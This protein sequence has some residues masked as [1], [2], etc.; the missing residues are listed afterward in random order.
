VLP[1]SKSAV[2]AAVPTGTS[3]PNPDPDIPLFSP[4]EIAE[5]PTDQV[6]ELIDAGILPAVTAANV[7]APNIAFAQMLEAALERGMES[8]EEGVARIFCRPTIMLALPQ[9][10]MMIGVRMRDRP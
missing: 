3:G 8:G 2:I 10:P 9:W 1:N 6:Q 5:L 7:P 4:L